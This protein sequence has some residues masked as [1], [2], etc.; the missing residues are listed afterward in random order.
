MCQGSG[1]TVGLVYWPGGTL[2]D[3]GS[4]DAGLNP[5]NTTTQAN[6]VRMMLQPLALWHSQAHRSCVDTRADTS[7]LTRCPV[8]SRAPCV[9]LQTALGAMFA[10]FN[11]KADRLT[12]LKTSF[13]EELILTGRAP[14]TAPKVIS[15]VAFRC[16]DGWGQQRGHRSCRRQLSSL[17]R[18]SLLSCAAAPAT[19]LD[20]LLL[21]VAHAGPAS[22]QRRATLS[23]LSRP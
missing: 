10:T 19:Q 2:E 8:P 7:V 9:S 11:V 21:A 4:P 18:L 23:A 20:L 1:L 6:L 16:A 3:W 12:V 15:L 22:G 14:S 17:R 5:C 13:P